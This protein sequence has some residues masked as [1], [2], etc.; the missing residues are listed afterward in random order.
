MEAVLL[1]SFG[2]PA[3]Q[4]TGGFQRVRRTSP[5]PSSS[6]STPSPPLPPALPR[7]CPG[8]EGPTIGRGA[9][10]GARSPLPVNVKKVRVCV[11][12][13]PAFSSFTSSC[14]ASSCFLLLASGF[15]V[16]GS[17]FLVLG[18]WS[19]V[20]GLSLS[21]LSCL[22]CLLPSPRLASPAPSPCPSPLT[23]PR[24]A[25]E[26]SEG[27]WSH[28]LLLPIPPET[29]WPTTEECWA[30]PARSHGPLMWMGHFRLRRRPQPSCT[31]VVETRGPR[32]VHSAQHHSCGAEPPPVP[33]AAPPV[34][35]AIGCPL[36][37]Y[38]EAARCGGGG[39]GFTCHQTARV[40]AMREHTR[41]CRLD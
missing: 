6:L 16:L 18:P 32:S 7:R 23:T 35:P 21:R 25:G 15:L 24:S 34:H 10:G 28:Q 4:H 39:G 9:R 11:K 27:Q 8:S 37:T 3:S 30:V 36:Y 1:D 20:L 2:C 22:S 14:F 17:W 41:A 26:G 19:L 12:A 40:C 31:A 33:S 13:S 38:T 29:A 5:L